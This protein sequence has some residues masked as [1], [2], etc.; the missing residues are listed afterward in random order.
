MRTDIQL[1]NWNVTSGFITYLLVQIDICVQMNA[2]NLLVL[3][4]VP[5][6]KQIF[7]TQFDNFDEHC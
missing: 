3:I 6:S 7:D 2:I 1:L 4:I 5:I